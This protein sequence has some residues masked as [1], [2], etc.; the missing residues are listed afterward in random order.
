MGS[1]DLGFMGLL[2][3]SDVWERELLLIVVLVLVSW[4]RGCRRWDCEGLA[5]C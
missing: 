3:G 5:W 2:W 1:L 4:E